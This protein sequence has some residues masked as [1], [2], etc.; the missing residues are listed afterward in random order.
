MATPVPR[1]AWLRLVSLLAIAGIV[2]WP[3]LALLGLL[4]AVPPV[5]VVDVG[6]VTAGLAYIAIRRI[7]RDRAVALDAAGADPPEPPMDG[8]A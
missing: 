7:K 5:A 8:I 1:P 4:G 6:I 3:V 2:A